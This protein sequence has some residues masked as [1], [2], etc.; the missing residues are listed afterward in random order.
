[1][2]QRLR[3]QFIAIATVAIS[4]ILGTVFVISALVVDNQSNAQINNILTVLSDN[5]GA[6]PKLS[7]TSQVL[8]EPVTEDTL[9]HYS[10]FSAIL[11]RNNEIKSLNI[12]HI[13]ALGEKDAKRYSHGI[14]RV[15]NEVGRLR[16][17]GVPYA[18]KVTKQKNKTYLL[19]VLDV[20][21]F[22]ST[23]HRL[24]NTA[25]WLSSA[26]LAFFI[27]VIVIFSGRVI[28]PFVNNY[29]KQRRFIT[30]AGHELKTPLAIISANNELEELM[31]GESEWT[32]STKDQIERLTGL[33]NALVTQARLEEQPELMLKDLNFSAI[34]E[35]AAEDFK[36][37]I[38]RDGKS[39]EMSIQPNIH[40]KAEEKSLFELVT[41]LV[42]NANKYCD[43]GGKVSV[44]LTK[45]RRNRR[46]RLVVSNTYVA[47][48]DI[49]YNRFFERF[50]RADESHHSE[51]SGYG[52]GLSIAESMVHLF[53]GSIK[54]TY[55]D[56]TIHFIVFL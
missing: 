38:L 9:S 28:R 42:D 3:L 7:E 37:P 26:C 8:G 12:G 27:L 13:K 32:K 49:D 36:G 44:L 22:A 40:I 2:F 46:S 21:V 53:K 1:M 23:S 34:A 15:G 25:I 31:N 5:G 56:D 16:I 45:P 47:G 54:V 17:S 52:I 43:A 20:S 33:I 11:S 14:F 29:K 18:Y 24:L 4:V 39:F 30:N 41:I 48:R 6:F 55:K 35:D 19:V 50:Y 10:Y 51:T